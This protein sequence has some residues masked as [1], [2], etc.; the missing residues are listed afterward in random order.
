MERRAIKGHLTGYAGRLVQ[1]G[2]LVI[3]AVLMAVL[4]GGCY[5]DNAEELLVCSPSDVS[6]RLEVEPILQARCYG[7]HDLTNAPALGDGINLEGYSN[8]YNYLQDNAARMVGALR[9]DGSG[10]PMPKD[11]TKL[12]NCTIAKIEVWIGEGTKNN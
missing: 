8:L 11:G 1:K 6:Y 9:W 2:L 7:C 3:A 5:F 4:P 12:D 10:S